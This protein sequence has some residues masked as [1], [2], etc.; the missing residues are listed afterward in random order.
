MV[1][2]L[3]A[4]SG[5]RPPPTP[6]DATIEPDAG[7]AGVPDGGPAPPIERLEF[8]A[9]AVPLLCSATIA[10][11]MES[12]VT[13]EDCVAILMERCDQWHQHPA[14]DDGRL[15]FDADA[16]GAYIGLV[17]DAVS[18]C[19]YPSDA[20][21]VRD[22][23]TTGTETE[24]AQCSATAPET[25]VCASG[26][27]CSAL[28]EFFQCTRGDDVPE[29]EPCAGNERCMLGLYCEDATATCAPA[30]PDGSKCNEPDDCMHYCSL[31]TEHLCRAE[32]TPRDFY[33]SELSFF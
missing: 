19:T 24:R 4:C 21:K 30:L 32:P 12:T 11:C 29:G 23:M 3:G 15:V 22:R 18:R 9:R 26:Y 5:S 33:C 27:Y 10:C 31:W 2:L 28:G 1:P 8:C 14:F 13:M 25:F 7:D 16:A 20:I 6:A 17:E